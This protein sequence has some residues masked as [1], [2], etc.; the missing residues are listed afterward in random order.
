MY[1]RRGQNTPKRAFLANFGT[2]CQ[3]YKGDVNVVALYGLREQEKIVKH[4][5]E[6]LKDGYTVV[7]GNI[8]AHLPQGSK[9]VID[10]Y[11]SYNFPP[12]TGNYFPFL[13]IKRISGPLFQGCIF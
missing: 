10:W 5:S 9:P 11:L 4:I 3:T 8:H 2:K 12:F 1:I 13:I 6:V 7:I